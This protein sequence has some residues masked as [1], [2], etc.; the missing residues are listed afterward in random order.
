[1]PELRRTAVSQLEHPHRHT[2]TSGPRPTTAVTIGGG[3]DRFSARK[4]KLN[5]ETAYR[6]LELLLAGET[7][8]R[9]RQGDGAGW[10]RIRA[11]ANAA[12]RN[13]PGTR[14]RA[15]S[16]MARRRFPDRR[17]WPAAHPSV[18]RRPSTI[19]EPSP[20]HPRRGDRRGNRADGIPGRHRRRRAA[21]A[22]RTRVPGRHSRCRNERLPT[23][24]GRRRVAVEVVDGGQH[25]VSPAVSPGLRRVRGACW[26]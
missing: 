15:Y 2:V 26:G 3:Y 1:V 24:H 12:V 25:R 8:G 7:P 18:A 10:R 17:R 9:T 6:Y 23:A 21:A 13:S 19:R 4:A 16:V 5:E 14:A 20:R 11:S 22:C